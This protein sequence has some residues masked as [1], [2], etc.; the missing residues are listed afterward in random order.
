MPADVSTEQLVEKVQGVSVYTRQE[1]EEWI[2]KIRAGDKQAIEAAKKLMRGKSPSEK[3]IGIT[4]YDVYGRVISRPSKVTITKPKVE[5][6]AVRKE[7]Y[8]QPKAVIEKKGPQELRD[9]QELQ[10]EA[11]RLTEK[12]RQEI[13][14]QISEYEKNV[15]E[16]RKFLQLYDNP[17]TINRI[18]QLSVLTRKEREDFIKAIEEARAFVK[19]YEKNKAELERY[20]NPES[21][22][23]KQYEKFLYAKMLQNYEAAKEVQKKKEI[24]NILKGGG[25]KAFSLIWSS[26]VY[27]KSDPFNLKSLYYIGASK[28]GKMKREEAFNKIVELKYSTI[29][30]TKKAQQEGILGH[31]KQFATAPLMQQA[32]VLI[33][34][35]ALGAGSRILAEAAPKV[36]PKAHR[37]L[38]G[39]L[40]TFA[41]ID[42]GKEIYKK[43]YPSAFAKAGEF[44]LATPLAVA[45]FKAGFGT[46]PIKPSSVKVEGKIS[47]V[48][49]KQPEANVYDITG[50]VR[51]KY[52]ITYGKIEGQQITKEGTIKNVF[53]SEAKPSYK[54]V[55]DIK[56]YYTRTGLPEDIQYTHSTK[57]IL[58]ERFGKSTRYNPTEYI[59]GEEKFRGLKAVGDYK[60]HKDFGTLEIY[61]V[62]PKSGLSYGYR[63]SDISNVIYSTEKEGKILSEGFVRLKEGKEV[64]GSFRIIDTF[65]KEPPKTEGM[66]SIV[67]SHQRIKFNLIETLK[68]I[69][70]KT[71]KPEIKLPKPS[72][73]KT[74][75]PTT[76]TKEEVPA[77]L[78][79]KEFASITKAQKEAIA[80]IEYQYVMSNIVPGQQPKAP[81]MGVIT[82]PERKTP[83]LKRTEDMKRPTEIDKSISELRDK[84]KFDISKG[85]KF[86]SIYKSALKRSSETREKEK[87]KVT[88]IPEVALSPPIPVRIVRPKDIV[89]PK[90]RPKE[91]VNVREEEVLEPKPP[92]FAPRIPVPDRFRVGVPFFDLG[93]KI[94]ISEK[95]PAKAKP[96]GF[97][98]FGKAGNKFIKVKDIFA[99]EKEAKKYAK[100]RGIKLID[101]KPIRMKPTI[102]LI[103]K[104]KKPKAKGL[105]GDLFGK[106]KKKKGKKKKKFIFRI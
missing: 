26:G 40:L 11:H 88:P 83:S 38:T 29:K 92:R 51:T 58:G 66:K 90:I 96:I 33:G 84:S 48:T 61:K 85:L 10:R 95:K 89:T 52:K 63:K 101:V 99:T 106:K 28:L 57:T 91:R 2:N 71:D 93:L 98:I 79:I 49:T 30:E 6:G 73:P 42:I 50:T 74:K 60:Y 32:Y 82:T 45:G 17:E 44:V 34:S 102:K 8:E 35:Y 100:M 7:E 5:K 105:L 16:A 41:G 65:F 68:S 43:D 75:A 19:G 59:V 36:V 46:A 97:E 18:K 55:V 20:K 81:F 27:S 78:D 4:D 24:E 86:A 87:E 14:K 22:M 70:G 80:D 23:Y 25:L 62:S 53:Y 1:R 12:R 77:R 104:P 76:T 64:K 103:D 67:K 39:G 3:E 72:E 15:S 54:N 94:D 56:T 21:R 31:A 13:L 9:L 69:Y 47:S 37:I